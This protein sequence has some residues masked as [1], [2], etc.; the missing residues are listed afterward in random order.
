MICFPFC[1]L[2]PFLRLSQLPLLYGPLVH[3]VN[4]FQRVHWPQGSVLKTKTMHRLS[5][6]SRTTHLSPASQTARISSQDG[7][8]TSPLRSGRQASPPRARRPPLPAIRKRHLSPASWT[9]HFSPAIRTA[10]LS[11]PSRM[12]RLFPASR[13]DLP[14]SHRPSRRTV[15]GGHGNALPPTRKDRDHLPRAGSWTRT[16]SGELRKK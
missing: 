15:G 7:H 4:C 6:A 5:P 14:W 12:H 16:G 1:D 9:H 10:R 3:G 13:T 8:V 11:P 2:F